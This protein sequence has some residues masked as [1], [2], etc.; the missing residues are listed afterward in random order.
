M[1]GKEH[2]TGLP[3]T[4]TLK[5]KIQKFFNSKVGFWC[6]KD[7][8][9]YVFNNNVEKGQLI[10][11]AVKAKLQNRRREETSLENKKAKNYCKP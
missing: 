5:Q 10:E 1:F 2:K 3:T 6:P 4:Q 11:V 7:G 8:S 9:D